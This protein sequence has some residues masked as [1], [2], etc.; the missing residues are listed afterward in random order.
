MQSILPG[1]ESGL[2]SLAASKVRTAAGA[3]ALL[4]HVL[5]LTQPASAQQAQ[6]AAD[7]IV[8]VSIDGL[9]PQYV[10][11]DELGVHLPNLEALRHRGSSADG[12]VGQYPSLTYPSH[13]SIVTGVRPARHGVYQ[14]TRFEGPGQGE[15]HFES[16]AILVPAL[17]DIA[18]E[19][20]LTTGG[21]SWPVTVGA[22]IDYLFPESHQNPPDMT[23]LERSRNDS[24][25]GLID[26]V[27]DKLGGFGPRDNLIPTERDRFAAAAATHILETY[28]PNLLM[29]HF[30]ETDF[31]Q[32]ATGPGSEE[33]LQALARIDAHLGS[34]V[35]AADRAGILSRT[36]FVITGDHGFYRIHSAFQPNV[37]LRQAGLLQTNETGAIT[38]WQAVAHRASIRLAD[39]GDRTLAARVEALFRDLAAGQYRGLL[40][41]VDRSTL[42]LL[43]ADPEALLYL[44]PA[45][46]YTIGPGFASDE[47]LVSTDRRGNH[48]YLP[49][50]PA[51][52]TGLVMAGAG[53]RQGV[54]L[55][56]ARQIDI[57]PTIARLLGLE[58]PDIDGVVMAGV[59]A[60][61]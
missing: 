29:V 12:V 10:R 56:I 23:W 55:A 13:T 11:G 22:D 21:V 41:V 47:F 37:V 8:L 60:A 46:G 44:E 35:A 57:A 36:A 31:A 52:H 43:G 33:T 2:P 6:R 38:D 16:E 20:G 19:S 15:W 3:A 34:L 1:G 7:H 9:M 40:E 51:M 32:H 54:P 4:L 48:G 61:D 24:T 25:P 28:R 30:V 59:L 17:W 42:D 45:E 26:A 14:N 18:R 27:V 58:M 53:V 5:L 39:P 49:D 50:R